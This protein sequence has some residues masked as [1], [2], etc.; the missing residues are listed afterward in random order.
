MQSTIYSYYQG[1][2]FIPGDYDY[3]YPW[4]GYWLY[5]YENLNI[6]LSTDLI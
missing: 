2:K 1:Y 3:I 5:S 4:N 6:I